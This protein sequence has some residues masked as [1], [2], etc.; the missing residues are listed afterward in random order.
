MK[1]TQ[2]SEH[3]EKEIQSFLQMMNL[4]YWRLKGLRKF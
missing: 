2:K 1:K 4:I 3:L